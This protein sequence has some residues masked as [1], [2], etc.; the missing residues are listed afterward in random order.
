M[1][2]SDRPGNPAAAPAS[3]SLTATIEYSDWFEAVESEL[4]NCASPMPGLGWPVSAPADCRDSIP[5]TLA[6][7]ITTV[8]VPTV[9][10]LERIENIVRLL[11]CKDIEDHECRGGVMG[12][13]HRSTC[14]ASRTLE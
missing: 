6:K 12:L 11:V 14:Q 7:A 3:L 2:T 4:P 10:M 9:A 13:A 8:Q 5:K 1:Y